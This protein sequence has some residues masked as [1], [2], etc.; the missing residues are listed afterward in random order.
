[1]NPFITHDLIPFVTN[2]SSYDFYLSKLCV[3]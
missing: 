1:M 2:N 3:K